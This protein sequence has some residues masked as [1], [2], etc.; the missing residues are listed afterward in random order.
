MDTSTKNT[1]DLAGRLGKRGFT[2]STVE[3]HTPDG[4]TWNA[5][6][7]ATG[8][9]RNEDGSWGPRPGAVGGF[10][11]FEV[12]HEHD[13]IEEHDAVDGDTWTAGDLIDY[14]AAV[15]AKKKTA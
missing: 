11:L 14:L 7:V 4:R 3:F 9:G 13:T 5:D 8:R 15:G 1:I 12:D 6:H 10:R 2:V